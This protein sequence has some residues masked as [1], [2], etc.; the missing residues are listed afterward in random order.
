M[1]IVDLGL[2]RHLLARERYDLGFSLE[3]IIYFELL[4]RGY[5]I[6][7]G[8]L[9][10]A[11]VDFVARKG[12]DIHYYQV[13]ASMVEESTFE[14]EMMPLRSISD[15]YSKTVIT[16]DRFTLGNYD[17]INVVNAVDWLLGGK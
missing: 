8:K 16:L 12:D 3:N 10:A 1:Y 6:N 9:G 2:R 14:R 17:G 13:T 15:N 4:R 5:N 7:I 11:E